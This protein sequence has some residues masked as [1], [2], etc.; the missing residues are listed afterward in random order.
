M[1]GSLLSR[2]SF[3]HFS[4]SLSQHVDQLV[5]EF[6]HHATDWR[7]LAAMTAG[8]VAY[9][10]GRIGAMGLGGGHG[11]RTLSVGIGLGAEVSA[12]ELSHRTL[13]T[14]GARSPRPQFEPNRMGGETP[15][16]HPENPNL[17]RWSGPG[18]LRQGLLS[19]LVTFSTLKGFGRLT[20]GQNLIARHLAQ[21]TGMVIG[22]QMT[23]A[24]GIA[25]KPEEPLIEQFLHAEATNLQI[26]AGMALGHGLM[27]GRLLASERG[28]DLKLEFQKLESAMRLKTRKALLVGHPLLSP[29]WMFMG[30]EG[31]GGPGD[32]GKKPLTK[33]HLEFLE[34]LAGVDRPTRR[35]RVQ[36]L[37]GLVTE[38]N[39]QI[40]L[41]HAFHWMGSTDMETWRDLIPLVSEGIFPHLEDPGL[42]IGLLGQL[43]R[44]SPNVQG[45]R[46][47]MA[48]LE[49]ILLLRRHN[50]VQRKIVQILE[51]RLN[52]ENDLVRHDAVQ[53]LTK[54]APRLR[55]AI[56]KM[57][58]QALKSRIKWVSAPSSLEANRLVFSAVEQVL[59]GQPK[60]PEMSQRSPKTGEKKGREVYSLSKEEIDALILCVIRGDEEAR[61]R[62]E[63]EAKG[64]NFHASARLDGIDRTKNGRAAFVEKFLDEANVDRYIELAKESPEALVALVTLA[65]VGGKNNKKAKE[66]LASKELNVE[67]LAQKAFLNPNLRDIVE[68]LATLNHPIAEAAVRKWEDGNRYGL[69]AVAG[70]ALGLIHGFSGGDPT[71]SI[72]LSGLGTLAFLGMASGIFPKI[73]RRAKE[74]FLSPLWMFM[75]T[76]GIGGLGDE[77]R[78]D[79]H[80]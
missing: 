21:D 33:E 17:W 55:S 53:I 62:L 73:T 38:E 29:L 32:G 14:V 57:L 37:L 75:G 20:Q 80:F 65:V 52:D 27:G 12:F 31:I 10:M 34:S 43:L 24:L 42:F 3:S 16:L 45:R 59:G 72:L 60:A 28:L 8:G 22:H 9:R 5:G 50:A 4:G 48:T 46:N 69:N 41:N 30:A 26:E 39:H 67:G 61:T 79:A 74:I 44:D 6:V 56:L 35:E 11:V 76:G 25:P 36:T 64:G 68:V 78:K 70:P 18:G 15:P 47:I 71:T 2:A 1:P 40:F 13:Q 49:E 7:S 54:A 58:A 77:S 66:A 63:E 23:G 51:D 19:S